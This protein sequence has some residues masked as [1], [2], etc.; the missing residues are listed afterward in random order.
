VVRQNEVLEGNRCVPRGGPKDRARTHKS[1]GVR[2]LEECT[3]GNG[4]SSTYLLNLLLTSRNASELSKELLDEPDDD[5]ECEREH[6]TGGGG[7]TN[8]DAVLTSA[9]QSSAGMTPRFPEQRVEWGQKEGAV[10]NARAGRSDPAGINS[11]AK[12]KEGKRCSHR[13]MKY[14][15]SL[16]ANSCPRHFS[17]QSAQQK[18][19]TRR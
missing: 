4:S 12:L 15:T 11:G 13:T 2:D 8:R 16:S 18:K 7:A 10:A 9:G 1:D 3:R 14:P 6:T 17:R 5:G 19:K